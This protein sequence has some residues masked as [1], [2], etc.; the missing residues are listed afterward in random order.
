[1]RR[2]VAV[3]SPELQHFLEDEFRPLFA[4]AVAIAQANCGEVFVTELAQELRIASPSDFGSHNAL[5]T[6]D[7]LT[8]FLDFE[9][10][11]WDD[12]VK[13]ASDCYWHPAMHLGEGAKAFWLSHCCR[14]FRADPS[15][16]RRLASYLP[17]F[18][19][20]WSLIILNE[21]LSRNAAVRVHADPRK[22]KD[23][24]CIRSAQ[25]DKSAALL[26]QIKERV[27]ELG[28]AVAAP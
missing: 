9:Y 14:I 16:R 20:K 15:F 8:L 25:L 1:M 6:G 28:S 12:P 19:L 26:R 10:F 11:G 3:N 7:G 2:L 21:F 18:G 17:L 23:L 27:Y 24:A 5:R 22:A 13:L 4:S